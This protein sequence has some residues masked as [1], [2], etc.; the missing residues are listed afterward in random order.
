M[1]VRIRPLLPDDVV[2]AQAHSYATFADL[3]RRLGEPVPELTDDLRRRAQLRIAHLQRTDP[4]AAFAA[5]L[6]GRL[7]GMAL[8]LRRGPLWFLSMLTVEPGLQGQGIGHRLLDAALATSD[9]APAGWILASPDPK[10]LRRYGLAGFA[11]HPGYAARGR[12]DRSLLPGGSTVRE[13]TMD[14]DGELVDDVARRLRGAPYGPDLSV[15][16][17]SGCRVLVAEDGRE[18]GYCVYGPPGVACLAATTPA[19]AQRLLWEGL[20]RVEGEEVEVNW[21][22]AD[23]QWA[24]DV[25]LA[26]RLPLRPGSSSCRR[27]ALGPLTPYL[28]SGAYG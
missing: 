11:L 16:A 27:G 26:A 18:R 15:F 23:Q 9:G 4:D 5:E 28:P 14:A 8:A 24:I 25:A 19:L 1:T 12:L 17:A 21:L 13:S 7:V 22:T 6:H 3:D 10:A 2:A 20:G